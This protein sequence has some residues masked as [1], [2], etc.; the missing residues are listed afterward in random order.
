MS[1]S[2][3]MF[4]VSWNAFKGSYGN[5]SRKQIH[6][7]RNSSSL[8][9]FRNPLIIGQKSQLFVRY[10][11]SVK[12][13]EKAESQGLSKELDSTD[14]DAIYSKVSYEQKSFNEDTKAREGIASSPDHYS[15]LNENE[16]TETLFERIKN[17]LSH[18]FS[19]K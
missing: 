19:K 18:T 12:S 15:S 5:A 17:K 9:K 8:A 4:A 13:K 7:F 2:K 10:D 1:A 11:S 16:P 3:K 6:C 14:P